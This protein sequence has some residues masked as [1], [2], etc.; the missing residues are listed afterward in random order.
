MSKA[1]SSGASTIL[2]E[3]SCMPYTIDLVR[4]AA[5]AHIAI[6]TEQLHIAHRD[7]CGAILEGYKAGLEAGGRPWVLGAS[8]AWLYEMVKPILRDPVGFWQKLE[9]LLQVEGRVPGNA[10]RGLAEMMPGKESTSY[11]TAHRVA[12][13]GRSRPAA[14]CGSLP[15]LKAG[16]SAVRPRLSQLPPGTGRAGDD[17][18][19]RYQKALDIAVRAQIPCTFAGPPD[20]AACTRLFQNRSPPSSPARRTKPN[21][22]TR[23]DGRPRT[24]ISDPGIRRKCWPTSRNAGSTGCIRQRRVWWQ[25]RKATGRNGKLARNAA[26]V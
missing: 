8:H 3:V 24:S 16:P 20:R 15:N 1:G 12:G 25:R 2:D 17:E 26:A 11:K 6:D 5:S 14:L 9:A 22:C 7:A 21:C 10:W 13:M 19:I 18:P 4:L 23:W